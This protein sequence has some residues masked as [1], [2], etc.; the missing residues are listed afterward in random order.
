MLVSNPLLQSI[1]VPIVSAPLIALL[2]RR[3]GKKTGW[4]VF[5]ILGYSTALLL[6]AGID[7]WK[8]S[9]PIYEEYVWSAIAGLKFG[10]LADGLSLPTAIIMSLI[11]SFITIYSIPYM[12]KRIHELYDVEEKGLFGFYYLSHLFL[13]VGLVG[14]ALSTNLIALY[15][16]L[17]LTV[18]SAYLMMD[19]FGYVE[20][21]RV[22]I[23]YFIWSH[24]GTGLF[25][26]GVVLA[27]LE[28]GSFD[29]SAL[30]TLSGKN[31][32]V[33]VSS[34]IL[35]GMLIKM[36]A[37]GFHVWLP[38]VH[39]EHLAHI[40]GII[41]TLAG[42]SNYVIV[43]LLVINL[44]DVFKMFSVPLMIW[45][46][47]TMIYGGLLTLAQDDVKRLYA[48]ST[49]SQTA[50]SLLGIASCTTLGIIG[51]IFYFLSHILGK[52]ILLCVAGII[53]HQT[54]I[55]DMRRLGGL[56]KLMPITAV[57]AI[58]GSMILSAIPP[59]SG[60]QAEWIMFAGIFGQ[61]SG[62]GLL[63][64]LIGIFATF[65]TLAYTFWPIKRMF[66]GSIPEELNDVGRAPLTMT[67]PLLIL[68]AISLIL[69]ICPDFVMRFLMSAMS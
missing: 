37:F 65:L 27:Y 18:I 2:G 41:A 36:A 49:I 16:F 29:V 15:L 17:E 58:M 56:A 35:V 53:V 68:S 64:A 19:L 59:L 48:C 22:A 21:H 67:I 28:G 32:A 25:L 1:I 52:T 60:F 12:E 5:G 24:I 45:A 9:T 40:A 6:M 43:R 47:V 20:R 57:L 30:S 46:L 66:F 42:L 10:F 51:G 7:V 11:S 13:S 26:I 69:G 38:H 62:T 33:L 3:I 8:S 50:Y 55:R 31:S 34:F 61:N 44:F 4:I 54:E 23:M 63:M 14:I 39:G